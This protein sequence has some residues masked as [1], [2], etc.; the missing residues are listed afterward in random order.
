MG[1]LSDWE[2]LIFFAATLTVSRSSDF[3]IDRQDGD[4]AE[5]VMHLVPV[6]GVLHNT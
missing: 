5:E 6:R 2:V 1:H 3:K 4:A